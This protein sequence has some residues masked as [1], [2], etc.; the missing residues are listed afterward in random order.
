MKRQNG[1]SRLLGAVALMLALALLGIVMNVK[2]LRLMAGAILL[3]GLFAAHYAAYNIPDIE[4]HILPAMIGLGILAGLGAD[5]VVSGA[6]RRWK[7][8]GW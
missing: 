7:P 3:V 4:G 1:V 8:A 5:A 6:R 2:R